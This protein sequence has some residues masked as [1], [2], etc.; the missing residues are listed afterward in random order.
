MGDA[1][2]AGGRAAARVAVAAAAL[3]LVAGGLYGIAA[4]LTWGH[5]GYHGGEYVIRA[6]HTLRHG[7]LLPGNDPG[8]R[9]PAPSRAYLHH[10]ILTHQ[11]VTATVAVLGDHEYAVRGAGLLAALAALLLLA[12]L[13]WRHWGPWPAALAAWVFVLVPLDVWFAAHIDPGFP[14]IAA[15][16]AF[17]WFYLAWLDEGRWR[18]ALLACACAALAGGFEWSPY[19]AAAPVGLHALGRGLRRR[20]RSLAFVPLYALAVASPFA[21]HLLLVRGAGQWADLMTS[22]AIRTYVP[23][24]FWPRLVELGGALVGAPLALVLAAWSV[25]AAGRIVRGRAAARDLVGVAFVVALAAYVL[26]FRGAVIIHGYRL[27]YAGVAGAIA[28]ADL[29]LALGAAGARLSRRPAARPLTAAAVGLALLAAMAPAAAAALAE[30]RRRGGIPL[31]PAYDP[32]LDRLAFAAVARAATRPG[33]VI[34]VH[35]TFHGRME[36]AATLDRDLRP[37]ASLRDVRAPAAGGDAGVL[38]ELPAL[39]APEWAALAALAQRHA[40]VV[41]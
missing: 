16:L 20:G 41:V 28:A 4:P 19:L 10:P 18:H 27:L 11:L 31:W 35:P 26:I 30:S 3:G 39:A 14:S 13:V 17:F 36:L 29:A 38:L 24:P 8:W 9:P 40:V 22:Y 37:V 33:D 5:H 1:V 12:A 25:I 21:L 23:G 15:L 34:A 2:S 32:E 6:R 7:A